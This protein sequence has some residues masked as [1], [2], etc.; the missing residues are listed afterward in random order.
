MNTRIPENAPGAYYVTDACI[1]CGACL[2]TAPENF[3]FNDADQAYVSKQP[4]NED[5]RAACGEAME[6]C[7]ADAIR[8]DGNA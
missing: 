5:E 1:G 7:P 4:E 2:D 6:S 3:A 8:D